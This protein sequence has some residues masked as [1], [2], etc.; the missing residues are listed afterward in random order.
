M[1]ENRYRSND[2][3]KMNRKCAEN[4]SKGFVKKT[5]WNQKSTFYVLF[6]KSWISKGYRTCWFRQVWSNSYSITRFYKI[7]LYKNNETEIGKK[8]IKLRTSLD[9]EVQK[10]NKA[11]IYISFKCLLTKKWP[12]HIQSHL[13]WY[14]WMLSRH[15]TFYF[16]RV[17]LKYSTF[18]IFLIRDN[19]Q[20]WE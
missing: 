9:W 12:E 5:L 20:H 8:N 10:K 11:M 4:E 3:P 2:P 7:K 14:Y 15:I 17:I 13:L 16:W 19:Y 1:Y 18:L 6:R